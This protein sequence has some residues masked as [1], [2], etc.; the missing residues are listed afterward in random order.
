MRQPIALNLG[1][2]RHCLP[3][4]VNCDGTGGEGIDEVFDLCGHWPFPDSSVELV[5]LSH[6]LEHLVSF[7]AFFRE[8]W[9]VTQDRATIL[10]RVPAPN[11]SE[12][13]SEPDHIRP[14]YPQS[15]GFLQPAMAGASSNLQYTEWAG[16]FGI[17]M[18]GMR[19]D[20]WVKRVLRWG[21]VVRK[22]LPFLPYVPQAIRE[23][24]VEL[25]T[26]KTPETRA[27]T[28]KYMCGPLHVPI[29]FLM[30]RHEWMRR[31]Y[32]FPD[33]YTL[34]HI[35]SRDVARYPF[36]SMMTQETFQKYCL[37]FT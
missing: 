1:A 35:A 4:F 3:G 23:L 24:F 5:Y 27:M 19:V 31:P 29:T 13:M 15:F 30:Y 28:L 33:D 22:A 14:W 34:L 26:I 11:H 6:V 37:Y 25:F 9:R 21:W 36:P 8:L 20:G 32:H 17:P 10:I 7:R 16:E 2:G 18:V 12:A